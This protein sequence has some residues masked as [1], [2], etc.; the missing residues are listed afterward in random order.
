MIKYLYIKEVFA[1]VPGEITLALSISN[2]QIQ[3]KGCNQK[4]LWEDKGT[5]LTPKH[6]KEL[7][8]E[9]RG[10]TCVCFMG[11]GNKEY[12]ELN[13]LAEVVKKHNL[14]VAIYL[15]EDYLPNELL[16]KYIDYLKLGHWEDSKGGLDSPNTNQTMYEVKDIG[17]DTYSLTVINSKFIKN[18]EN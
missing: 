9:H 15:G 6:L 4:E 18:Y 12:K 14:K 2:C 17:D 5:N 7:I 11:S 10:I 8:K 13:I 1:E 3:C 16:L